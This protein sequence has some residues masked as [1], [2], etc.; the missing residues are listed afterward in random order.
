MRNIRQNLFFAFVYNAAGVPIAAGV[1]YPVFGHAALAD[2]RGGR[3]GAVVGQRDR[4]RAAAEGG[5]AVRSYVLRASSLRRTRV[6]S[7]SHS[8]ARPPIH[9]EERLGRSKGKIVMP[10]WIRHPLNMA[11]ARSMAIDG[12]TPDQVRGDDFLKC[13]L[14][15]SPPEMARSSRVLT[16]L[17]ES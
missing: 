15:R 11:C 3:H 4:Q 12:W 7:H 16:F 6:P 8:P 14:M 9:A 13:G 5:E 1:L 10:D 2:D 17:N